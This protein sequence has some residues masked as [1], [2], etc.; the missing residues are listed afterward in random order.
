METADAT[1][2]TS[3]WPSSTPLSRMHTLTP[4]PVAPP[5]AHSRSTRSGRGFAIRIRSAAARGND[6]AGSA[7]SCSSGSGSADTQTRLKLPE[8]AG[9]VRSPLRE[10]LCREYLVVVRSGDEVHDDEVC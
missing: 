3:E 8:E 6:Q 7:S 1:S 2:P 5:S 9:N 10:P 4:A